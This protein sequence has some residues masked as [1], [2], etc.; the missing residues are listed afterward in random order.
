MDISSNAGQPLSAP[1]YLRNAIDRLAIGS[2][3]PTPPETLLQAAVAAAS[4]PPVLQGSADREISAAGKTKKA[5]VFGDLT[6]SG[7]SGSNRRHSAWENEDG[8]FGPLRAEP[9]S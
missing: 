9:S 6:G 4:A 8:R 7:I 5:P 2:T 3:L 1:G